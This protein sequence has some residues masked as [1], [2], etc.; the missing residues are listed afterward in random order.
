MIR[1]T[2]ILLTSTSL[3]SFTGLASADLV[4]APVNGN[5]LT[6]TASLVPVGGAVSGA[7]AG[8]SSSLAS[9]AA[10][11]SAAGPSAS[12]LTT[13]SALPS[14]L[15]LLTVTAPSSS[16]TVTQNYLLTLNSSFELTLW[17]FIVTLR[18]H[19]NGAPLGV[20]L[21][22]LNNINFTLNPN[23]TVSEIPLPAAGWLFLTGLAGLAA[24]LRRRGAAPR[25]APAAQGTLARV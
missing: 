6:A 14:L 10:S 11:A 9:T 3:L 20:A 23:A 7:N 25:V 22:N 4:M 24:A 15:G 13:P 19:Q 12:L 2:F 17:N 1:R 18:A 16:G 5:M 21:G 8:F